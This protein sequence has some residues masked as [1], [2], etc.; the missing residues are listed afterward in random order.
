M[1]VP[2]RVSVCSILRIRKKSCSTQVFF[3][4]HSF[5]LQ[6]Y[7]IL[8]LLEKLPPVI[9]ILSHSTPVSSLINSSNLSRHSLPVSFSVCHFFFHLMW[10]T[11]GAAEVGLVNR[12]ISLAV[13]WPGAATYRSWP[14][15]QADSYYTVKYLQQN[16]SIYYLLKYILIR[17]AT[18]G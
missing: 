15:K 10:P 8:G 14:F 1:N 17:S 2:R 6:P 16:H 3:N 7:E 11:P 13:P 5:M 9:P 12:N 4:I 18:V